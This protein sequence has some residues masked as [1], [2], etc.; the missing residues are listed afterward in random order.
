MGSSL[1][2]SD[3]Y[4]CDN[5][6]EDEDDDDD[7]DDCMERVMMEDRSPDRDDDDDDDGEFK[8]HNRIDCPS[9]TFHIT[10]SHGKNKIILIQFQSKAIIRKRH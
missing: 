10:F 3:L 5:D 7:D 2:Y 8:F 1:V 6:D 4:G 9:L